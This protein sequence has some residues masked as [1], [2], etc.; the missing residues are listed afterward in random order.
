MDE[1]EYRDKMDLEALQRY[2]DLLNDKEK[3]NE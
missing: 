2:Y 1:E 3:M